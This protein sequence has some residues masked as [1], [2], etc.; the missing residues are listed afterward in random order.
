M[1]HT[2]VRTSL[3]FRFALSLSFSGDRFGASDPREILQVTQKS[4]TSKSYTYHPKR[5][6]AKRSTGSVRLLQGC[7]TYGDAW[8]NYIV[9]V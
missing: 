6:L 8:W 4:P 7:W 2:L 5:I 9:D 1:G 3:H